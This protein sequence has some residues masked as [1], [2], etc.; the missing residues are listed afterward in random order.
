MKF[1]HSVGETSETASVIPS[2]PLAPARW[3]FVARFSRKKGE[4]SQLIVVSQNETMSINR[5]FGY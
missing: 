4:V 2:Q 5:T 1:L 3:E